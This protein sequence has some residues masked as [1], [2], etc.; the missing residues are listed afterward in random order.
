METT[1][2]EVAENSKTEEIGE[3]LG[4][5]EREE[6]G[7]AMGRG[8]REEMGKRI[9]S[10]ILEDY[11]EL[12]EMAKLLDMTSS[13]LSNHLK[14][15]REKFL[16]KIRK[17]GIGLDRINGNVKIMNNEINQ[18]QVKDKG[19]YQGKSKDRSVEELEK[20]LEEKDAIIKEYKNIIKM[21][22]ENKR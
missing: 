7:K 8:E 15:P 16:Y 9:R 20:I 5:N 3:K 19:Q 10:I 4:R 13:Q 14:N 6:I 11:G 18:D 2:K 22:Q 12:Q 21:L 17:Q 1:V